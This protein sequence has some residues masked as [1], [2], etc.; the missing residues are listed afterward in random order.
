MTVPLI[1]VTIKHEN[2]SI[3]FLSTA[4]KGKV[5]LEK[6]YGRRKSRMDHFKLSQNLHSS[7][8]PLF[9]RFLYNSHS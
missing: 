7:K 2:Y 4:L 8:T 5:L 1:R 9:S 6:Q 3:I